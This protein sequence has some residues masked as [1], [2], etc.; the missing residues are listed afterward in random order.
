MLPSPEMLGNSFSLRQGAKRLSTP[1]ER[2]LIRCV[3]E[4]VL[5]CIK[6]FLALLVS[7][8]TRLEKRIER[9]RNDHRLNPGKMTGTVDFT[10][11]GTDAD[12]FC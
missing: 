3:V 12:P 2:T 5:S 8:G 9:L 10:A 11:G 6:M 4:S 1:S 7:S